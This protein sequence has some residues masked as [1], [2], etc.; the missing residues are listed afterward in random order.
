[1][2]NDAMAYNPAKPDPISVAAYIARYYRVEK[3]IDG[4]ALG[5]IYREAQEVGE[6]V[7]AGR[8][9]PLPLE[10]AINLVE[11][12]RS[13]QAIKLIPRDRGTPRTAVA[14]RPEDYQPMADVPKEE[15]GGIEFGPVTV[16]LFTGE[17]NVLPTLVGDQLISF[18][19]VSPDQPL[20]SGGVM[21][22]IPWGFRPAPVPKLPAE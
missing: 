20:M 14:S 2:A 15:G 17:H 22:N 8:T 19:P 1:M 16:V 12:A 10:E 11:Q 6:K 21:V 7:L 18:G 5:E 9:G 4:E 13:G 3:G